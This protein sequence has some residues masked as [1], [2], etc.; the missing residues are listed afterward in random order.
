MESADGR[1]QGITYWAAVGLKCLESATR[2]DAPTFRDGSFS[3][4]AA[5]FACR[6]MSAIPRERPNYCA[7]TK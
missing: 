1:P 4:D 7:A 6:S 3:T 2:A 5:D